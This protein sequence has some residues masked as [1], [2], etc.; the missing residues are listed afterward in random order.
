VIVSSSRNPAEARLRFGEQEL[1]VFLQK[2]Y[3]TGTLLN[4][5]TVDGS[6]YLRVDNQRAPA[7]DLGKLPAE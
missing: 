1:P 6:M 2:P 5:V 7:D 4:V 3:D